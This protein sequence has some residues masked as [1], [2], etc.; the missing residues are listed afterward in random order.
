MTK[1]A[2]IPKGDKN[3]RRIRTQNYTPKPV[4]GSRMKK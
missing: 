1:K 4:K 2:A 3:Q